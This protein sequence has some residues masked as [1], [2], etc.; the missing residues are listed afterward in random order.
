MS[1]QELLC[2]S[3]LLDKLVQREH[4]NT[5]VVNLYP[6]NDGYS[7]MLKGRSGQD[8]ETIRLPYDEGELLDY[9]DHEQLPPLLADL[10]D[11]AQVCASGNKL[12]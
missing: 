12:F 3:H 11:K 10:L 9:I 2:T 5:L 1:L 4:L 7:L 8:A 6:G